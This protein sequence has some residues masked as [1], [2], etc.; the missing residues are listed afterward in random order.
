LKNNNLNHFKIFPAGC[1]ILSA[2]IVFRGNILTLNAT[3]Y[4]F[5]VNKIFY[6][7]TPKNMEIGKK[8]TEKFS[9]VDNKSTMNFQ[10]SPQTRYQLA[11][12]FKN[13]KKINIDQLQILNN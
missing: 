3:S 2:P 9:A 5:K 10:K 12:L 6:P 1:D 11:S 13:P 7:K 8:S 4:T